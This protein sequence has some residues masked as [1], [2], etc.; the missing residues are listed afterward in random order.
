MSNGNLHKLSGGIVARERE[1]WSSG[2]SLPSCRPPAP[3][4]GV[5]ETLSGPRGVCAAHASNAEAHGHKVR[6]EPLHGAIPRPSTQAE[7]DQ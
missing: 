2:C 7:T 1:A 3:V 4:V 5:I 6:R